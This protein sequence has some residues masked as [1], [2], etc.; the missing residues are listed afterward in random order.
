MPKIYMDY[1]ATTPV[2]P[3]VIAAMLPYL[4]EAWGNPSSIHACGQ[5][6][7]AAVHDARIQVAGLVNAREPSE[8]CFTSGGTE[9]DNWALRGVAYAKRNRGNHIVTSSIEHP[10]INETCRDLESNGYEVTY[11]PVDRYGMVDPD[12]VK[13]ALRPQTVLVSVMHANNEMGTIQPVKE[14]GEITRRAGVY[15][16]TDAV[17][18]VGHIPVDVNELPVD[19]LT[20]SAHKI[21]GPK[22]TGAL[23]IR[24]G[25]KIEPLIYG[26]G[27]EDGRRSGTENVP[28]IVGF[29]QAALLAGSELLEE[30][31][32]ITALRDRLIQE[33]STAIPEVQLNG[34]PEKRLPNNVNFSFKYVEGEPVCLNLDLGG[35]A[36]ATGSACSSESAEASHVLTAMGMSPELA[37]ASLRFT[38]GKWSTENDITEL[39]A[40]LPG[41]IARLRAISPLYKKK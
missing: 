4:A 8:I 24:R 15:F 27:Q 25:V 3:E 12:D 30:S 29:G 18:T 2:R 14:I 26:G 13:K 35:I 33:I 21:Y 17:Q 1:A 23:Y 5:V 16:H 31:K 37:R 28:G 22:G 41:I 6:P 19:L 36:A 34:H 32:R 20:I 39:M 9:A 11:L 40:V 10:A 7:R 38:L